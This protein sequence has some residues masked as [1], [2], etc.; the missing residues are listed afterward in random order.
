LTICVA[1]GTPSGVLTAGT[2]D[3]ELSALTR[4]GVAVLRHAFHDQFAAHPN[5]RR[6]FS[7]AMR[8]TKT[9]SGNVIRVALAAPILAI[10]CAGLGGAG[11]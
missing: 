9:S 7:G 5:S 10:S 2:N 4:L 6:R 11:T 1:E 8:V 3:Q